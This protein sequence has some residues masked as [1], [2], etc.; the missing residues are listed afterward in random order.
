MQGQIIGEL[1]CPM[2][3]GQLRLADGQ[4]VDGDIQTGTLACA[5]G[6]SF[7]IRRRVPR[8]L[9]DHLSA[10]DTRVAAAF[11]YEWTHFRI[12]YDAVTEHFL[13]W[14]EPL[15][16]GDFAGKRVV[17][18]GCGMGRHA[19]E[20]ARFGAAAVYA[21]DLSDAVD[22]AAEYTRAQPNV[23]VIQADLR[24]PPL[25][26]QVDLVYSIG[27]LN[28][29]PAPE[30]GFAA[31]AQLLEP[32]GRLCVWVYAAEAGRPVSHLV[33]PVRAHVTSRLPFALLRWATWPAA[34]LLYAVCHGIYG[35]LVSGWPGLSRHLPWG[36]Y[37]AQLGGFPFSL[38]HCTI[39]DQLVAPAATYCTREQLE[40]YF[41][42]AGLRNPTIT[43]RHGNGWRGLAH[44]PDR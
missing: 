34:A 38:L 36:S 10:L 13:D 28:Q 2:C 22:V 11:G 39:F 6:R 23:H 29:L 27:V 14:I 20:A 17:D 31:L 33:D 41:A 19:R 5:C 3:R 44:A 37:L 35:P 42:A 21:L 9:P 24:F 8:L 43:L 12:D 15:Q 18:A 4:P 7:P 40:G 1:A 32:G 16:R 30:R 25:R 26:G